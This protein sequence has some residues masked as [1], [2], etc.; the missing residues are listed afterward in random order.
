MVQREAKEP[1]ERYNGLRAFCNDYSFTHEYTG[2]ITKKGIE[3]IEN[4]WNLNLRKSL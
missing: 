3:T 2:I 1:I 4:P